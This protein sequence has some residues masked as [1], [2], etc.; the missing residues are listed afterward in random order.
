MGSQSLPKANGD[1]MSRLGM[2]HPNQSRDEGHAMIPFHETLSMPTSIFVFCYT[3]VKHMTWKLTNVKLKLQL[4]LPVYK[5][6]FTPISN[7]L[8]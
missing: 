5:I 3:P 7:S 2:G 1:T 8:L 6:E 4:A